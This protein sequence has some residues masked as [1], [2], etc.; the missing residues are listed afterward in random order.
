MYVYLKQIARADDTCYS[1]VQLHRYVE[2]DAK[3]EYHEKGCEK[4]SYGKGSA[5][6]DS[7][8]KWM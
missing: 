2:V 7:L 5:L 1:S 8:F 3:N 4:Y 6:L